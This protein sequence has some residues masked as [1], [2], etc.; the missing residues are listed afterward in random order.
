ML[1]SQELYKRM[2]TLRI[3]SLVSVSLVLLT[4]VMAG[5]VSQ[6]KYETA[7]QE[8]KA[9]TEERDAL[10]DNL[11]LLITSMPLTKSWMREM[12]N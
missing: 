11:R 12:P 10:A 5:C 7:V 4:F 9:V 3:N 1:A 2:Q 6:S 8:T